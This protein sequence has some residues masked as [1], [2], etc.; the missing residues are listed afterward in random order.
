[1]SALLKIGYASAARRPIEDDLSS[2]RGRRSRMVCASCV[3]VSRLAVQTWC[4]KHDA[5]SSFAFSQDH[6]S[7][8]TWARDFLYVLFGAD[9]DR[10]IGCYTR[11]F[12][13]LAHHHRRFV[14]HERESDEWKVPSLRAVLLSTFLAVHHFVLRPSACRLAPHHFLPRSSLRAHPI[15]T[16]L[17]RHGPE[18][19]C[20][21]ER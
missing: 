12:R 18:R 5:G 4:A 2:L 16:L 11:T 15:S 6:R 21:V 1:M 8:I 7:I 3:P 13:S 19:A 9:A 20:D 17:L 14:Y 10:C